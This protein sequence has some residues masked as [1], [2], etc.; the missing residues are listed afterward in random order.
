[1]IKFD[2]VT[3]YSK[4]LAALFIF[5]IVPSLSFCIGRQY[6]M[7]VSESVTQP[8]PVAI[9][10]IDDEY[11]P[12]TECD[13]VMTQQG[14]NQCAYAEYSKNDMEMNNLYKKVIELD[15]EKF[16]GLFG[17]KFELSQNTWLSYRDIECEA[18]SSFFEGGSIAPL[19][20]YDC[21]ATLTRERISQL[22]GWLQTLEI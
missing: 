13:D 10:R 14:M 19:E 9:E 18:Q 2:E 6:E 20:E 7:L 11:K 15:K 1:M 8:A 21:R 3:W 5:G 16:E 17:A 4:L 12:Y 22:S